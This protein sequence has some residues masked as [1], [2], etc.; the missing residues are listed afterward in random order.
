VKAWKG[1]EEGKR[2]MRGE[3]QYREGTENAKII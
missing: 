1:G 3:R 2:I